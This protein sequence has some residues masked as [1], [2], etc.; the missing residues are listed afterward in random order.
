MKRMLFGVVVLLTLLS[1]VVLP[2][3]AQTISPWATGVDLQNLTDTA[4]PYQLE[5][6]KADGTLAYTFA[7]TTNL[8]ARG[9]AN[10]YIPNLTSLP[11]GQ[12]SVVV[13]SEMLVAAVA[14][15]NSYSASNPEFGGGDIYLGT[16]NPANTL[17][18]PLAYRNHT[19]RKWFSTLE[20]QNA[21]DT[22]QNVTLNLYNSGSSA[23]AYSKTVSLPGNATYPFNLEDAE[24]AAFGPFGG[25]VVTGSAPLAG[26][27]FSLTKGRMTNPST[28]Y[29]DTMNTQYRAFTADQLGKDVVAPL[30]YRNFNQWTTGINVVNNS[31]G[32]TQVT[33]TYVN[34]N[35]AVSGGPW[36]ETKTVGAN[37][38][39]VFFT[40]STPGLPDNFYGSATI[41]SDSANIAVV[42]ASQR[43]RATGAE[44]VAYEGQIP[45]AATK[46]VSLPVSHNRTTWKTGI[47]LL[48][49]G[50]GDN[51]V[52]LN[53]YSSATGIPNAGPQTITIPANSPKTVYMPT[54]SPTT[55][56]FYGAVDIKGT[57]PLLV[58]AA[59][60]RNDTTSHGVASNYVGVNYTCP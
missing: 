36:T 54:D 48:N 42:V 33:V 2:A 9:A 50:G 49:L 20:V 25:A 1:L 45:T 56:G 41:H 40:P 17:I 46:C 58:V 39:E 12:Y 34:A 57:L 52:T 32:P 11:A 35:P 18:F 28:N 14:S 47:N 3:S 38:M 21:S 60:S 37:G 16:A 5:F 19:V 43:Y 23:V 10:V 51:T 7:S 13:S 30:L 8:A 29:L 6:Y 59:N 15:L 4:T 27:A 31:A 55:V 44:G 26:V 24:Y 22:A 53:Y